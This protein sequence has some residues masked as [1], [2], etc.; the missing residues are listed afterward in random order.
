MRYDK[1]ASLILHLL[2]NNIINHDDDDD[3]QCWSVER[4]TGVIQKC[5]K[6]RLR[7]V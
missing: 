4:C 6:Q 5:K 3:D 7:L 1:C 2:V